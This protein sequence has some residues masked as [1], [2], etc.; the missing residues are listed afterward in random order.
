[1]K[2]NTLTLGLSLLLSLLMVGCDKPTPSTGNSEQ[3]SEPQ[4]SES[5][6]GQESSDKQESTGGEESTGSSE[7][8]GGQE[9]TGGEQQ[10][11]TLQLNASDLEVGTIHDPVEHNG[12]TLKGGQD[13]KGA[14]KDFTV[15][16]LENEI[17]VGE[18]TY[19]QCVKT[20][21]SSSTTAGSEYRIVSFDVEGSGTLTVVA[22]LASS[23][24]VC[25]VGLL[26]VTKGIEHDKVDLTDEVAAYTLEFHTSGTY[27]VT[28]VNSV[29]FYELS[30]EVT[31][32][33]DDNWEPAIS[34]ADPNALLISDLPNKN[35]DS[36][37]LGN[38]TFNMGEGSKQ[39]VV[40][41][42]NKE[43]S[44]VKYTSRLKTGSANN[45]VT[46]NVTAKGTITVYMMSSNNKPEEDPRMA[47]LV[48]DAN[49]ELVSNGEF[50]VLGDKLYEFIFEVEAGSYTLSANGGLNYYALYID[51]A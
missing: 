32:E 19:T 25:T 22:K 48:N 27:Y 7:S 14:A 43:H 12:F 26:N 5:V 1:M 38:F 10:E 51:L 24:K 34:I 45:T 36:I 2:K 11:A 29:R 3:S 4:I 30:V 16:A 41:G 47:K 18:S 40:E 9:S 13:S 21:G 28:F 23:D 8:T 35:Y 6:G 37:T 15:E 31:G 42:N 44:G 39:F 49:G 33:S 20:G 17:T 46:F 50:Q